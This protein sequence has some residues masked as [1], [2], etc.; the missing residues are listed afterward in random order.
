[1]ANQSD[2]LAERSEQ[3]RQNPLADQLKE[4][5]VIDMDVHTSF[6][7]EDIQRDMLE[8]LDDPFRKEVEYYLQPDHSSYDGLYPT[9]NWNRDLNG[10]LPTELMQVTDPQ[11][12]I[13]EV[14]SNE[15]HVDYPIVNML[16]ELN[17]VQQTEKAVALNRAANKVLV[18]RFLDGQDNFRGLA[19]VVPH[20]PARAAE[21]IDRV[22]QEDQICGI[23]MNS[24]GVKSPLGNPEYDPIYRAAEDN[25]LPMVY[26]GAAA[27]GIA[28]DFPIL[29][30]E[31]Q[32]YMANHA[33]SHIYSQFLTVT[34]LFE[35]GTPAKFPDLDFVFQE[36]GIAWMTLV[37]RLNREYKQRR[38]E[39]PLLEKTPEEY[40]RDQFYFATQP[41]DEPNDD[42]MMKQLVEM[43]GGDALMFATDH[44]HFD[45]DNTEALL[46][47]LGDFSE[48]E[49]NKVLYKNSAD[50]FDIDV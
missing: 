13:E 36:A 45:I 48:E 27:P 20:D 19:S 25:D 29:Q 21:E 40:V 46:K 6:R 24:S 37:F 43:W 12:D 42:S 49:R 18:E 28:L 31:L 39:L 2:S 33:L 10:K 26:H 16:P 50:V 38:S 14:L 17:M 23:F 3:A 11:E 47:Y 22:A 44:P 4:T 1:M 7:H 8:H 30:H 5:P 34:S 15:F 32:T 41:L 35:N 9:D